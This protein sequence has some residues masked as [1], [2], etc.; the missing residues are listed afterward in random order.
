[1]GQGRYGEMISIEGAQ[2][3][4]PSV[5]FVKAIEGEG[6][7]TRADRL[8]KDQSTR[9]RRCMVSRMDDYG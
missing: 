2:S 5:D 8:H 6:R 4:T 7:A 9:L 1:M 3:E